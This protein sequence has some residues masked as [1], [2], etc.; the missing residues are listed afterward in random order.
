MKFSTVIMMY[1]KR[2]FV[3]I[4]ILFLSASFTTPSAAQEKAGNVQV[5]LTAE[6]R[7]FLAGKQLRLGIDIARPPF[8]YVDGKGAYTGISAAFIIAAAQRLGIAV[9]PMKEIKWNDAMEKIKVGEI[10]VIPKVTPSAARAKFLIFTKPYTTFPSVIVTRKDRLAGGM[11]DLRGLKVGVNKGQIVEVNLKRD[12]PEFTLVPYPDIETGLRAVS[13]GQCDTYVDNLGAVAY[14]IDTVGLTNLRI[15]ASTPYT[16]DLAF[17]VR[18]DWPLLASALDKALAGMT[19]REKTEIKNR[20][21]A[22]KYDA[23]INWRIFVPIGAALLMVIAFFLFWNRRL[24]KAMREREL[25]QEGLKENARLLEFQSTI[26]AQL[27]RIS[28]DLQKATTLEEL[29]RTFLSQVAALTDAAYGVF[30][31]MDEQTQLLQAVG[32][33]GWMEAE[34]KSRQFKIGQGL[35]GQCAREKKPLS[36]NNSPGSSIRIT[37][38]GGQFDPRAILLMPVLE[39]DK[40]LAVIELG[41]LQPFTPEHRALLDEIIPTVALNLSIT[42]RNLTTQELLAKGQEQIAE[43]G[44]ARK[45]TLNILEDLA[46]S[47]KE[48]EST[49]QK[50][51]AM[52]R[53]QVAIFESLTIGIAFVKDRIILRGNSKLGELFGRP[54]DEMIGQTTRIWYKNDEEYSG[55]GA[56]TYEDLKYRAMHQREQQLPR[57]DGSLFWCLFRVRAFDAKDISQGIVCV[58]EDITERKQAE[59]ALRTS[60][61]QMRTLV[62]SFQS[63]I[64]MKDAEGRYLL[65][66][67]FNEKN[68]GMPERD[69]LGKTDFDILPRELA[70]KIVAQDREVMDAR[71][72]VTFEMQGRPGTDRVFLANKVPLIDENGEVYGLCGISTDITDR[73]VAEKELGEKMEELERFSRLTIN[74]EEKM[75]QLKEEINLLLEQMG[76]EK[77]YKI[78]K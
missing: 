41:A 25:I 23:G 53:E 16:H 61:N 64:F 8:E 76:K 24:R 70:E 37:W 29:A 11:D 2:I 14:T 5:D 34:A 19:D 33:Y 36:F 39:Q 74:R 68:T 26:K 15:A 77:R 51:D 55:I 22:I 20:W 60:Q 3:V 1:C 10:D 27:S 44:K 7:A 32:G 65:V 52:S 18:K 49:L 69:V 45:A 57:K 17:G 30:F 31:L 75:I 38:G 48:T 6:E 40:I 66:N 67:A 12:H 43:L 4:L 78:V 35:P 50:I 58:L 13:T 21:L 62:D 9:V 46:A 63:L 72:G 59:A 54:L 47:K 73:K 71:K 28:V 56:S 42:R